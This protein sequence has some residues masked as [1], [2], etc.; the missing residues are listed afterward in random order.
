VI[1]EATAAAGRRTFLLGP[2]GTAS[3]LSEPYGSWLALADGGFVHSSQRADAAGATTTVVRRYRS[4]ATLDTG[5]GVNGQLTIPMSATVAVAGNHLFLQTATGPVL[6]SATGEIQSFPTAAG[7]LTAGL[8]GSVFS[9]TSVSRFGEFDLSSADVQITR[10]DLEPA[11]SQ[12]QP[13]AQPQPP[14]V[15]PLAVP[16][17]LLD[18]RTDSRGGVAPAPIAAGSFLELVVAGRS[19]VP[20]D[21]AAVAV[22][23]TAVG[24]QA[25]G[26]LTVW[27]CGEPMPTASNVNYRAGENTP[28]LVIAK[29]GSGGKICIF[30]EQSTGVIA[31]VAAFFAG[32][33]P[34]IGMNPVRVLETRPNAQ[35]V[36]FEG[37]KP[38]A[39]ET[40]RIPLADS[41]V[42]ADAS[43]IVVNVTGTDPTA[44][45]YLTV[46]PCG[47]PM[48]T[49]S[50][51]NLAAGATRANLVVSKLGAGSAVCIYTEAG[52]HLVADLA[53][54]FPAASDYQAI[55]PTRVLETRP[56]AGQRGYG[57]AKPRAGETVHLDVRAMGAIPASTSAVVLNVTATDATA[58]GF[59]TVWPCGETMPTAS[60]LNLMAGQTAPNLVIAKPASDGTVC[61][62]TDAG[63][64]LIADLAGYFP[65]A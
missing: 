51:L 3:E 39:G 41:G 53:G 10:L 2:D 13:P 17:R 58:G 24:P 6:V 9:V 52:A 12:P 56:D 48:P 14:S 55:N 33:S 59:V 54:Y 40:I 65:S 21:A 47:E 60:N 45:G 37:D 25:D 50:N 63:T 28:N 44:A 11:A 16:E 38:A 7:H 32:D 43:A 62:Y 36:N 27:P 42:P 31:D 23:I 64:H 15:E 4:D 57:G 8:D 61:L 29:L 34:F 1:L 30:S 26:Y 18:T 49:A 46:W 5:F 20:A 22:N 19:G 35:R